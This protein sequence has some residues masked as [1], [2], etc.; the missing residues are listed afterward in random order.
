LNGSG[1]NQRGKY[2]SAYMRK[3]FPQ[4]QV[5]AIYK[6]LK[7]VPD[8]LKLTDMEQSLLQVDS[9]GGRIN[10]VASDE[11]AV[12]QRSSIMKLQYQTYWTN[13]KDDAAHLKWISDFYQ[14][15]YKHTGGTP[16]PEKDPTGN[17]DGCYYNYPDID[18][19]GMFNNKEFALKLYFGNNLPRLK[20]TKKRWD[21]NDYFNSSQ[22]I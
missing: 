1:A 15:V 11:T 18:L 14:Y 21:P 19:N 12:P 22:S 6:W 3:A 20:A 13:P 10:L 2:K 9:Y 5:D 7:K 17:V 8:G 4:T 16:D